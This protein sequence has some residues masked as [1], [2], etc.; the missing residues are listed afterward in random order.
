MPILWTSSRRC[1]RSWSYPSA[2]QRCRCAAKQLLP[3]GP[4]THLL[5]ISWRAAASNEGVCQSSLLST[6]FRLG[7]R[8]CDPLHS[9]VTPRMP[10]TA[11]CHRWVR[12]RWQHPAAAQRPFAQSV[13]NRLDVIARASTPA[14]IT[15]STCSEQCVI[16]WS[17]VE[18]HDQVRVLAYS[19]A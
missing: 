8:S 11:S 3:P 19:A 10:A 17:S 18:M 5:R 6:L 12:S 13:S 16:T 4:H 1:V 9:D 2:M 7:S 15:P 14:A